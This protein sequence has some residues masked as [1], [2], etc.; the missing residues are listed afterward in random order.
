M[1]IPHPKPKVLIKMT[2]SIACY[3]VC[4]V[5][6]K[7]VQES[8]EVKVAA[9]ESAQ[10]FVGR[11]T[12]E[13][14]SRQPLYTDLWAE[15]MAHIELMR[16][17]DLIVV[18][19]ATANFINHMAQGLASDLLG[20][21]YLAHD[22]SKPYWI[23]PAMNQAMFQHPR[24]QKSL[25]DLIHLGIKV[26]GIREG[27]LACGE[28]GPGRLLES[29]EI[30]QEIRSFFDRRSLA[31]QESTTPTTRHDVKLTAGPILISAGGTEE[32][33]DE[34]RVLS[35]Q[36]T[37]R[38][39]IE[40]ARRLFSFGYPVK[41]ILAERSAH[42]LRPFEEQRFD[43][44]CFTN[45]ENLKA[46][47]KNNLASGRFG[48]VIMAAAVSDFIPEIK[49]GKIPS[50]Q[51]VTL[52]LRKNEKLLPQLKSFSPTPIQVVGFKLTVDRSE[53]KVQVAKQFALGNV[54]LVVQ[55]DLSERKVVDH[56]FLYRLP[57]EKPST[58]YQ[59]EVSTQPI[60]ATT[61]QELAEYLSAYLER[62]SNMPSPSQR[63]EV[64]NDLMP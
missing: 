30:L 12:L 9:S 35:N 44:E 64:P 33:I 29:H 37:G 3:K 23:F 21:M 13:G 61:I 45:S 58:Q 7:L 59:S 57:T 1:I 62:G 5:I 51:D 4:E 26:F 47:L 14:L 36:S 20:T 50:D 46:A 8:F 10:R 18:A 53:A 40:L 2:G 56:F 48:A 42:L 55:N 16:W 54:D 43:V 32:K 28:V 63:K 52:V 17:A 39:G 22:F 11:A 24:V 49:N 34:V 41:L 19:P 25:T 60:L 27:H 38:T 31:P 6:S 15:P